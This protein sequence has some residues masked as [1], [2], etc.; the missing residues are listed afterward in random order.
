MPQGMPG[1]M[2]EMQKGM[3]RPGGQ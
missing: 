1:N 2:Q 3:K